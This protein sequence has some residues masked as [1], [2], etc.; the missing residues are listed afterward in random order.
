LKKSGKSF[1]NRCL[2]LGNYKQDWKKELP[3]KIIAKVGSALQQVFGKIA[4][5]ASEASGVIQRQRKFTAET[6]LQTFVL[7]FLQNPKANDEELAQM[8]AQCGVAVSAQAIDQRHSPALVRFLEQVFRETVKVVIGSDKSLAPI[9]ERFTS[10]TLLDSSTFTLPDDM[11]ERFPGCGGSYGSGAAAMK[12]QTEF[13]LRSGAL[14]HVEIESGR[15][16]D[17]ASG[18]QHARRG[19]G[20]L[21]ISDLGYFNAAV[22]AEMTEAKEYFLSR[23]QFGTAV[24]TPEGQQVKLLEWLAKQPGPLVDQPI[25]LGKEQRLPC[26]LIAWRLPAAQAKKRR[27]KLRQETL[28]KRGQEPSAERLAWCDWTIL[29]TNVPHDILT[30]AEAVILYRARWQIELLFKRWKSQDLAAELSGSSAVRQMVRVWSRLIGAVIQHWLLLASAWGD[31]TKSWGKV[32]E[33]IRKF[34]GRIAAALSRWPELN[35]VLTDLCQA[36]AKTCRRNKRKK[37]GTFELLNDVRLLDFRL[38]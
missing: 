6:L 34:V 9:L 32:C 33:A 37:P 13:D 12:L 27:R 23:L 2:R 7:G 11:Q 5:L 30:P 19:P 16:P 25:L 1:N 10:V 20:S 15:S 18:R 8:A 29:V 31:P 38:T 21:R 28:R 35:R 26:R 3:M 4:V 14:C 24:L 22:F 17:G 36:V